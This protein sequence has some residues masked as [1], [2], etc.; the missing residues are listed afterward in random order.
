M[1]D[2]KDWKQREIQIDNYEERDIYYNFVD[3]IEA[4]NCHALCEVN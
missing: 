1:A 3:Y 4:W 2:L